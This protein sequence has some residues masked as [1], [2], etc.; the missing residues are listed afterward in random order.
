MPEFLRLRGTASSF[1][2]PKVKV[3]VLCVYS[4]VFLTGK[5]LWTERRGMMAVQCS[6]VPP[7]LCVYFML[8]WNIQNTT[9]LRDA[10]KESFHLTCNFFLILLVNCLY[11]VV[12]METK[13]Q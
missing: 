13:I 12:E 2:Y 5:S 9:D 4:I 7:I 6:D 11:R 10:K 8:N 3:T 1:P